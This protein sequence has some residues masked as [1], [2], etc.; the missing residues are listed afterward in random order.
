MAS[1]ERLEWARQKSD[2]PSLDPVRLNPLDDTQWEY[3]GNKDWTSYFIDKITFS[4][5]HQVAVS[6]KTDK[7]TFYVSGGYDRET[8]FCLK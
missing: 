5:S 8:E 7:T 2:N 4:T 3:M 1:D 6:G